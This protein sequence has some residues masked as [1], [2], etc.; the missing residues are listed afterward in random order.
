MS[1]KDDHNFKQLKN[2]SSHFKLSSCKTNYIKIETTNELLATNDEEEVGV[3]A[4]QNFAYFY[5]DD[6]IKQNETK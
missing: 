3:E 5:D 6:E 2:V 1:L 4:R